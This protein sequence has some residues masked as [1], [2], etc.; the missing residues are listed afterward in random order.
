MN[1]LK[2]LT[3]LAGI[4]GHE[5]RVKKYIE[6]ELEKIN[7]ETNNDNLGSIIAVKGESGPKIMI[8]GHMDE[9]GLIV[10]NITE[11]GFIKFQTIG[12]WFS[13]V[14]ISKLWDIHTKDKVITG[15]SGIKPPHIIPLNERSKA[16]PIE[17]LFIDIGVSSKEEALKNGIEI[18]QM[19]TPHSEYIELTNKDY[20]LSKAFD[21]RIGCHVVLELLKEVNP[22]KATLYGTFT[23]QEEVGVRGAK[24]SS[25]VVNPDISIAVDT[26]VGHDTPKG[27]PEEQQL[28]KGPQ[29]FLF[30]ARTIGHPKL[31]KL[32]KKIAKDNDIPIQ[33][34]YLRRGGT[35][36]GSMHISYKGSPAVSIG[37]P[38]RYIHSHYSII[39]KKD[40]LNTI[41]L[42]KCFVEIFDSKL[43]N[44]LV[45]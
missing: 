32:L 14:M 45:Q 38:T 35:D 18:G 19:I 37:I 13:Q 7:V 6:K 30:D 10:S 36:A 17:D 23:V 12:G 43:L 9:I 42:L 29:I 15:V 28:G 20:I 24:T 26:G 2:E 5:S 21:N 33:Q 40:V 3:L 39:H 34:P 22:K 1:K 41:K 27:Q 11:N 25:Y 8:A 16:I 31:R 44:G 4:S